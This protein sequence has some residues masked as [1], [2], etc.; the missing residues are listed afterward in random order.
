M[1]SLAL[2]SG[3]RA[4]AAR[5]FTMIELLVVMAILGVLAAAV[6][7]LGETLLQAQR[8]R[9]LRQSLWEIR[10]ALDEYKRAMGASGVPLPVGASGYPAS[11]QVLVDGVPDPSATGAGRTLYFLRKVPRDPMADP[12]LPAEQTWRQRSYASSATDPKPG[13]D[14]YDV[15]S[16]SDALALDG[17]PFS[18]W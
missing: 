14:V 3:W 17:T 1:R 10:N 7:P 13:V 18:K 9:E 8:E 4:R 6:M 16:S 2:R 15:T 12:R 5:G 11:L